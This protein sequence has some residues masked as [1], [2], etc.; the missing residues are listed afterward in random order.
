MA[1]VVDALLAYENWLTNNLVVALRIVGAALM[2]GLLVGLVVLL[3][4]GLFFC[5]AGYLCGCWDG[6]KEARRKGGANDV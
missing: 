1:A 5:I 2:T 4:G 3:L 6:L